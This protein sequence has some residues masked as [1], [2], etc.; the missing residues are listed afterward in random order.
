MLRKYRWNS[1]PRDKRQQQALMSSISADLFLI[2]CSAAQHK[3]TS[4]MRTIAF[5]KMVCVSLWS[6]MVC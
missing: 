5:F 2:E 3:K 4:D 6:M 1:T